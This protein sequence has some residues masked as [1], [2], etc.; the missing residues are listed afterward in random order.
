MERTN[1]FNNVN[2]NINANGSNNINSNC[3]FKGNVIERPENELEVKRFGHSITL[4]K[5]KNKI[6]KWESGG[7]IRWC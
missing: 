5:N 2:A 6:S 3:E 4:S 7:V 1:N